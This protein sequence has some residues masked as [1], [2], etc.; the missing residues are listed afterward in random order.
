MVDL[1][2]DK[3][4]ALS[5]YGEFPCAA[6]FLQVLMSVALRLHTAMLARALVYMPELSKRVLHIILFAHFGAVVVAVFFLLFTECDE[7]LY[8]MV[9]FRGCGRVYLLLYSA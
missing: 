4:R 9:N 3:K 5:H 1:E 2:I 7:I 8:P 6:H